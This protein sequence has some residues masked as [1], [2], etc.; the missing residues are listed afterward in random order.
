MSIKHLTPKSEEELRFSLQNLD[1]DEKLRDGCEYGLLWLVKDAIEG[2]K[3]KLSDSSSLLWASQHGHKDIVE[4]LLKD[5]RIDPGYIN[6]VAFRSA[7]YYGHY[8]IVKL[9]LKDPR[10]NPTANNNEALRDAMIAKDKKML[11][12]LST[13]IRIK[14]ILEIIKTKKIKFPERFLRYDIK[15]L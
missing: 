10:V 13:D 6:C 5:S 2:D 14:E 7:V 9:L 1:G 3:I 12:I 8:D 11:E 4:Y 15:N